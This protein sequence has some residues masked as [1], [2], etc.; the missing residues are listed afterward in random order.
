MEAAFHTLQHRRSEGGRH[1]V[2]KSQKRNSSE[3]AIQ[4]TGAFFDGALRRSGEL[5]QVATL[6]RYKNW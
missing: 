3:R 6:E 2:F 5:E 1:F 4:K